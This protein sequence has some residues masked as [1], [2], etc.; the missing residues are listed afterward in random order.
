MVV[1][2]AR[3]PDDWAGIQQ[4][5]EALPFDEPRHTVFNG[6]TFPNY[7]RAKFSVSSDE[8]A[9]VRNSTMLEILGGRIIY[10]DQFGDSHETTLCII[11]HP[12]GWELCPIKDRAN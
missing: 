2:D 1:M 11:N 4:M 3:T 8:I 5:I 10:E 6:D 9:G 7:G 12:E